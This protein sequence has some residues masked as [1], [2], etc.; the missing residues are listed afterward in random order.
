[1]KK[2]KV[3]A[4]VL[5]LGV[6]LPATIYAFE[7]ATE[8]EGGEGCGTM[9]DYASG[10]LWWEQK[11]HTSISSPIAGW[12]LRAIMHNVSYV[13]SSQWVGGWTFE[14]GAHGACEM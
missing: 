4:F 2:H 6:A 8:N 12:T 9:Y 3:L 5:A 7:Q 10:T 11:M 14:T 13:N 1:M